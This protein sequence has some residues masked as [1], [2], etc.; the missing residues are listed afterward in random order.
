MDSNSKK[1]TE[2]ESN[3][4]PA[5][6]PLPAGFVLNKR[7]KIERLINA[8]GMGAVYKAVDI[9]F[10]SLCAVKELLP[11]YSSPRSREEA[12][13]WFEREAKLLAG[14][15]HPGLPGVFDYFVVDNNYYLVMD[16]IDGEDLFSI[17]EKKG[18]PGLP[19]EKVIEIAKQVLKV[20]H[21][22]HSQN[23]PV[24]YRDMKPGNIMAGRDGRV[25][26]VDFGIAKVLHDR[27]THTVIGTEGYASIEQCR[28][29]AEP[30]SDIYSLGATMHHLLTGESPLPFMFDDLTKRVPGISLKLSK[31]VMK[32]VE[33]DAKDRFS[34]AVEML[35]ALDIK[36]VNEF[37]AGPLPVLA[38]SGKWTAQYTDSE[39]NLKSVF[40]LDENTGWAAGY[41]TFFGGVLLNTVNGG[42]SWSVKRKNGF[43]GIHFFS[44]D[45]GFLVGGGILGGGI[46]HTDNGGD[47]WNKKSVGPVIPLLN[48]IFFL[49]KAAGWIVGDRGFMCRTFNGGKSWERLESNV[50]ND[51]YGVHFL[52]FERGFV[53]GS[54]GIILYSGDGGSTWEKQLS[55]ARVALR[56]VFF[57][58]SDNVC[59]AGDLGNIIQSEA[60]SFKEIL[61]KKK[62]VRKESSSEKEKSRKED[63]KKKIFV[64]SIKDHFRPANLN[65]VHFTDSQNGWIV[66]K[67]GIILYTSDGGEKWN[68]MDNVI[69]ENLLDVFFIDSNNGWAVGDK[70]TI[71]RYGQ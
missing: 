24:L 58:D 60:M 59:F 9:K 54:N 3:H 10:N 2:E 38:G 11:S 1:E 37:K 62:G 40:F 32:A 29:K 70:G 67:H 25:F 20:L 55:K 35:R 69:S 8:G 6:E 13:E 7:Y 19:Q 44:P 28:G 39:A 14:L 71:L 61:S 26:L 63:Y 36:Q 52:D 45:E 46:L 41:G 64:F 12:E 68:K 51:L 21:Y 23:P 66:G 48:D 42:K 4:I 22:L 15:D 43:S 57:V 17:L 18:N 49:N 50:R 33:K 34:S 53:C 5:D 31:A 30:R 65:A 27:R 47:T 16:F 56:D